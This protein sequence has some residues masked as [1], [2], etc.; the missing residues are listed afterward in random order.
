MSINKNTKSTNFEGGPNYGGRSLRYITPQFYRNLTGDFIWAGF[1][2]FLG[3]WYIAC[4]II[5]ISL[6]LSLLNSYFKSNN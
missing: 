6:G 2:F 1:L 4:A 5:I 3:G